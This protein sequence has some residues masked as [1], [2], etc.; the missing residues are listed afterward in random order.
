MFQTG[1]SN[2]TPRGSL[3]R[4]APRSAFTLIELLVV[5]AIVAILAS[6]LLP[7]LSAAKDK[8]RSLRCIGN[9]KQA[10]V[11]FKIMDLS[12]G[13]LDPVSVAEQ[14]RW[15][16]GRPAVAICPLA[17]PSK[18]AQG[19]VS[20]TVYSA[21]Q[22]MG[23]N[24]VVTD[25]ASYCFNAWVLGAISA[26]SEPHPASF[27]SEADIVIPSATPLVGDGTVAWGGLTASA[28]PPRDLQHL[29][30]L[31][32]DPLPFVIPRH[33][34]RPRIIPTDHP[35]EEKLPGAINMAFYDGH[36]EQVRLEGLWSL[37]WHKSYVAPEKR[38]GLK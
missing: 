15:S 34:S 35:L 2:E 18:T 27:R 20:G 1:S 21:W 26:G 38:P 7:A 33:G 10:I 30:G 24:Q 32:N 6:L 23:T 29:S 5:I 12:P 8:A 37:Y 25:S 28:P 17:P 14:L 22:N 13:A 4:R 31:W 11:A 19:T 9:L 3:C 16:R 36:V